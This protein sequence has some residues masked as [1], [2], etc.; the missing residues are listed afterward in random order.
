MVRIMVT[1]MDQSGL[2]LFLRGFPDWPGEA[3]FNTHLELSKEPFQ[4]HQLTIK[5]NI[6]LKQSATNGLPLFPVKDFGGNV[7]WIRPWGSHEWV[8]F[9]RKYLEQSKKWNGNFWLVPPRGYDR[10]DV[11]V[12]GIR[13]RPAV[14]CKLEVEFYGS[15]TNAHRTIEV[16]NLDPNMLRATKGIRPEDANSGDFRSDDSH[17][18][19]LDTVPRTNYTVSKHGVRAEQANYL[20]IVHELGHAIGLPHIGVS[21]G[22][23]LCRA[24]IL[25]EDDKRVNQKSLPAILQG[26]SNSEVCYGYYA[27]SDRSANV[28]GAGTGFDVVNAKPWQ[29][30]IGMH[31]KTDA[32]KWTVVMGGAQP[33]RVG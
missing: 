4:N 20:T 22:D 6:F 29:D 17:Y 8:D 15:A 28:M 31:T 11:K 19:N 13:T 30:R 24:A 21:K 33:E 12:P 5:L 14:Y 18:D 2:I 7:F 3:A 9:Q 25:F 16:S 32:K 26:G 1:K 23:S 10:L 27:P